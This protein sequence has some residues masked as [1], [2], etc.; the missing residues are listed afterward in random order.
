VGVV[1]EREKTRKR[2]R[3][4]KMR[5]KREQEII[6]MNER[7]GGWKDEVGRGGMEEE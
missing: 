2:C 4:S 1:W 3:V 6:R 7:M 5:C